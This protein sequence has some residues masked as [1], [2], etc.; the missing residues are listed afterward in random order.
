MRKN[1]WLAVLSSLVLICIISFLCSQYLVP[2]VDNGNG[3]RNHKPV[4]YSET[5]CVTE[6][7]TNDMSIYDIAKLYRDSNATVQF[8]G[9]FK[10]TYTGE[11]YITLGSGVVV[12]STGYQTNSL[13]NQVTASRGS[14]I[15]TNYHVVEFLD[16][17]CYEDTSLV[18]RA[19]D[20]V[21]YSCQVLWKNKN[22]DVAV[23]YADV[24][25][26]YIQMAD[27][28]IDC[29]AQYKL[30]YE[31]AFV[32]GSPLEEQNLNRLT[33]GNIASNNEVL[34][35]TAKY[36]YTTKNGNQIEYTEGRTA[37]SQDEQIVLDNVYEK[38]IDISVGISGGNSGGGVFDENGNLIGLA[39]LGTS[40]E[41]TGG[42]Q[43]N[44]AVPIYPVMI[45]LDK[46][47]ANNETT[48]NYKIYSLESFG[49]VGVDALEAEYSAAFK[50]ETSFS[51][52]YVNGKFYAENYSRY[53]EFEDDGYEILTNSGEYAALVNMRT[54]AVLTSLKTADGVVHNIKKRNDL[55][56]LILTFNEG[57]NI[58][59]TYETQRLIGVNVS[60]INVVV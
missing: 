55:L 14:Y 3:G 6:E 36:V 7:I 39:T 40:A 46:I 20:E 30:D 22:L 59:F 54:G 49:L 37:L 57:D 2:F 48:A 25:Y 16:N 24:S 8:I 9:N 45:V 34:M 56:Y 38:V 19:E 41:Q 27:R 4:V 47:I 60:R 58:Q 13:A 18:V 23:V 44:G 26:N 42:N 28:W 29:D 5:A 32:I 15:A 1:S 11:E 43:I 51:H 12:A 52:Y 35:Y 17:S 21:E 50:K 53:F 10:D 33:I 31:P